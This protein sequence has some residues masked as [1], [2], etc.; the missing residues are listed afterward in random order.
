MRPEAQVWY[1]WLLID[2]APGTKPH[3]TWTRLYWDARPLGSRT[4]RCG[5]VFHRRRITTER[6]TVCSP[7]G[8][9]NDLGSRSIG[10]TGVHEKFPLGRYVSVL[11]TGPTQ[12]PM[13]RKDNRS[14]H[15]LKQGVS[16]TYAVNGSTRESF[17]FVPEP[18]I[19][20]SMH[21]HWHSSSRADRILVA[22]KPDI[23]R[24]D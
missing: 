4:N 9:C 6:V 18:S 17:H 19:P 21:T 23:P 11:S 15:S 12:S 8:T 22:I 10:N 1:I 14:G 2:G 20:A 13:A 5:P 24:V 7:N 3:K 16:L